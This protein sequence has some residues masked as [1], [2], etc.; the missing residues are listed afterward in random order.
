MKD[1]LKFELLFWMCCII[2]QSFIF[3]SACDSF[4]VSF[5]YAALMLPSMLTANSLYR[6]LSF[7]DKIQ[8]IKNSI[9]L[10]SAVII[11]AYFGLCL[12]SWYL[13]KYTVG[14]PFMLNPILMFVTIAAFC[15]FHFLLKNKF[16]K[17]LP[18]ETV[19]FTSERKKITL[20]ISRI[21]YIESNDKEVMVRLQDGTYFRT[22][23]N[24]SRW[25]DFLGDSFIRIHRSYLVNKKAITSYSTD[26]IMIGEE[27][28]PISRKY[29][30]SL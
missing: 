15:A 27:E 4:A 13:E 3:M 25:E 19:E 10:A 18:I 22:K 17:P 1:V 8:G 20:E 28:L 11:L 23:M 14:D 7:K 6:Q 12:G 30:E 21:K 26:K 24:I 16:L 2:I 9:Y 5:L 29:R